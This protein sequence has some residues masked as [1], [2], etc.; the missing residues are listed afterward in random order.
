MPHGRDRLPSLLQQRLRTQHL[1]G[2]PLA[3]PEDVVRRLGAVQSQDYSGAKWSLGMRVLGATDASIDAAFDA[4]RILRTHVLRPTWHFVHPTDIRWMQ[5]LTAPRVQA[6]NASVVR[7]VSVDARTLTRCLDVIARAIQ[8]RG[9]RTRQELGRALALKPVAEE[10][11]RLAYIAMHAE[12]EGLV[13]SGPMRGKE[14]TYAL[15]EHRAPHALALT[16]EEALAELARRFFTGHAPATDRHFAWW[17]GLSLTEARSGIA[18]V[19]DALPPEVN[20]DGMR[21]IGR[22][23]PSETPPK[24]TAPDESVALLVPEYD[25]ALVGGRDMAVADMP[26]APGAERWTDTYL[27]PVLIDGRR[28]GTWRRTIAKKEVRIETN[29]FARLTRSQ[30]A[31]LGEAVT[32]YERFIRL[33]V[34]LRQSDRG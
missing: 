31:L 5:A 10:G 12:L 17:S 9:P 18:L 20:V 25:E 7:R 33:P 32:R 34:V 4:G 24:R 16:R 2:A 26:R 23:D 6:L 15:L 21:W 27:R 19:R 8:E 3:S 14:H 28:A 1:T 30:S 29:L 22:L 11:L 13:C